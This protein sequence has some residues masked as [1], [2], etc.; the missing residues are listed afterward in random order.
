MSKNGINLVQK[1]P[2]ATVEEKKEAVKSPVKEVDVQS[3]TKVKEPVQKFS[4]S[5]FKKQEIGIVENVREEEVTL[6]AKPYENQDE[7]QP[8]NKVFVIPGGPSDKK[9][10][11]L[12]EAPSITE[13]PKADDEIVYNCNDD[14]KNGQS[15]QRNLLQ[16]KP[17]EEQTLA[18][19][20]SAAVRATT[21]NEAYT[22][23]GLMDEAHEGDQLTGRNLLA[24][25]NGGNTVK[26]KKSDTRNSLLTQNVHQ[27]A[28]F[29][30]Q[31][32]TAVKMSQK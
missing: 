29:S 22:D 23:R 17:Q 21:P 14:Q 19:K 8:D 28:P 20:V 7:D 6:N 24:F 1:V 2:K 5:A 9:P 3:E 11:Q 31:N 25:I 15:S 27:S 16:Y 18:S 10:P 12:K 4:E 30:M 32:P 13:L 26:T